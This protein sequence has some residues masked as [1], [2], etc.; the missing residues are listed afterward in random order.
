MSLERIFKL[1][2]LIRMFLLNIRKQKEFLEKTVGL[3]LLE[4]KNDN[5]LSD[6]DYKKIKSYYGVSVAA[7]LGE[8]FCLLRGRKMSDTERT[9]LTYLGALTGLFDDFFDKKNTPED[10]IKE[11]FN[12][13]NEKLARNSHELLFIRLYLKALIGNNTSLIKEYANKVFEAQILSKKQ[14]NPELD[15]DTIKSI[16]I[17]KGGMSI[18]FY[19]CVFE[20]EITDKEYDMLYHLGGLGQLENDL[21]DVYKDYQE[22]IRTLATTE[23][24]ISKLRSIYVTLMNEVFDLLLQTDFE[25]RDQNKFFNLISLISCRGLVCLDFLKKTEKLSNG[26]FDIPSYE[27]KDLVCDMDKLSNQL[28]LFNYFVFLPNKTLR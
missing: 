13:P 3:D 19:R 22:Q 1:P 23:Q 18:L 27:R 16:T 20:D 21:F 12:N 10:H 15:R 17:Q 2:V 8:G 5:N 11:M 14:K 25:K 4:F 26:S 6:K 7:I 28:K 9:Q 24:K